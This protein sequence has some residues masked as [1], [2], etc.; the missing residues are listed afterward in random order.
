M[1]SCSPY[2]SNFKKKILKKKQKAPVSLEETSR[3]EVRSSV[4]KSQMSCLGRTVALNI[5][6]IF[7]TIKSTLVLSAEPIFHMGSYF[8]FHIYF[9]LVFSANNN[10]HTSHRIEK[11]HLLDY[12][13][14]VFTHFLFF[15]DDCHWQAEFICS[16]LPS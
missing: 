7:D 14:L 16:Q 11:P 12:S 2:S 5:Q 9:F 13:Y 4:D 8:I 10:L 3:Y 6:L 15:F 1:V